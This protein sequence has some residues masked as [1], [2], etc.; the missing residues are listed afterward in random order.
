MVSRPTTSISDALTPLNECECSDIGFRTVPRD[1]VLCRLHT[2]LTANADNDRMVGVVLVEINQYQR[3][4]GT[5]GYRFAATLSKAVAE[6]LTEQLP[7][8]VVVIPLALSEFVVL[9]PDLKIRQQ[10]G[11]AINKIRQIVF[12]LFSVL[13]SSFRVN[14]TVGASYSIDKDI[15]PPELMRQADNA[16]LHAHDSRL[17][18]CIHD[19]I[20]VDENE[21]PFL[22]LQLDLERALA[23]NE[24]TSVFQPKVDI[25][26]G[27]VV[28]V[29]SLVRWTSPQFGFVRPDL[30]IATAER[31]GLIN[32]LTFNT[33]N[34]AIL[35]YQRWG[36]HAVPIAVNLSAEVIDD[37]ALM[38]FIGRRNIWG[39]PVEALTLEITE[40]A[41][42]ENPERAMEVFTEFRDMGIKLSMDDFGTGY[43]SFEYL[44]NIPIQEIKIDRAFI[45]NMRHDRKDHL[46]VQTIAE[47]A[48]GLGLRV[49]AEGV[50]D[51]ETYHLAME[52][53][54]DVVQGYFISRPL[55]PDDFVEWLK[56][57][58]WY[59]PA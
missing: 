31:A 40:T 6:R 59:R 46:I 35:Q 54:C 34:N 30:I 39:M 22:A 45:D 28:G 15:S 5:Y 7:D 41:F 14:V 38:R 48:K 51:V 3:I 53:G 18:Q 57:D 26:T 58:E 44:K 55:E 32:D 2:L 27:R 11:L 24:I 49:I 13:G 42:M 47:L 10:L 52:A 1:E 12:P 23:E 25:H 8:K 33:L 50:E 17:S 9:L 37:P 43:S 16:L 36:E 21:I 29:E 20:D 19:E 56:A 4:L